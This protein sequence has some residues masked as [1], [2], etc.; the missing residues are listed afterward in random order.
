MTNPKFQIP[1]PNEAAPLPPSGGIEGGTL[2]FG[3]WGL[4]LGISDG[5]TL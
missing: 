5:R 1:N 2:R 4:G 3:I